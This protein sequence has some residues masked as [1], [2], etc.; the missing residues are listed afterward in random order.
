AA[1]R[2]FV[3]DFSSEKALEARYTSAIEAKNIREYDRELSAEPHH[4]GSARGERNA[5]WILGKMRE[6]GLDAR[7]ETFYV[8]FPTPKTRLVELVAPS[9]FR[10]ALTEPPVAGDATSSQS[11]RQLPTYN[12][13]SIDGDVTAP[14]VYVN[15]GVPADYERLERMGVDV[16]GKIVIARYGASWRGIKP[17]VAAE[18]GAVGC[19]IYSDP[20]DDGYF[21]GDPYPQGAWRPEQGVQRGSVADMPL[22]PGDPLTPGVGATRD[23]RRL[24]RKDAQTLTKIPV[25]PISWG[26]ARPLLQALGGP[27][28]PREWRGGLAQTYHLGPGP[29]VVHLA[30]SFDWKI[31]PAHDVIAQIPGSVWPDEWVIHG[32]HHDAWVNGAS[33]PV[34]GLAAL[35]EEARSLGAL[36]RSG[37][38]PKRSILLCAWDGEEPG[39]LGSTEWVE[40]HAEELVKKAVVYVNTDSNG[41]GFLGISGSHTLEEL[42]N[43]V[44]R[45]V[46]DPEKKI[47]V[48]R[49]A[50]LRKIDEARTAEERKDARERRNL[51]IGALGSGSDFTPFLQHLGIASLNLGFGG[52]GGGG[53]YHS[54]YDD[55]NWY[56]KFSDGEFV[57]GKALAETTGL[58]LLRLANA[59][60]L[61]FEFDTLSETIRDYAKEVRE[62]ADRKRE[63][64]EEQSR[65]IE[66]GVPAAMSDP[67]DPSAET[68]DPRREPPV[69]HFDFAPLQNASDSLERA[70]RDYERAAKAAEGQ[71]D[72]ARLAA[73]NALLRDTER[74]MTR[75]E[76]LPRRPWFRHYVYA[77]GFYTGYDVKTL[78][79]VREA[80]EEKQ[81]GDVNRGIARTAEAIEACAAKIREATRALR[82]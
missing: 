3:R 2:G 29:A 4:V 82:P 57:Y 12:A 61:P 55:F 20:R 51:K 37:W 47:S 59:D 64:N 16:R 30:L 22:Y 49:R 5:K 27:V 6:W 75:E 80:I 21:D 23:A 43:E 62:L 35:L 63:E 67:R 24:D 73:V 32:N 52:E 72:P 74:S 14:L 54:I 11:D 65:K 39:L 70:A 68:K 56:T 42:A 78:P 38:K 1:P 13:Y 58:L 76:G 71:I 60:L 81:W 69:P 25:L 31:V 77:P 46:Q 19:L 40:T 45:D 34:S 36:V 7:I 79:A 33:D 48:E 18:K 66:E 9:R 10:A 41:R 17:K 28:A 53:V 26:D 44:E 8:L 50:R 15:Y